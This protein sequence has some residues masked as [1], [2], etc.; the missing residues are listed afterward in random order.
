VSIPLLSSGCQA[1]KVAG[2]ACTVPLQCRDN[3][4]RLYILQSKLLDTF[5]DLRLD[6]HSL[7]D[8]T[9]AALEGRTP[10]D[11]RFCATLLLSRPC[12]ICSFLTWTSAQS[13]RRQGGTRPGG[14]EAGSASVEEGEQRLG[15]DACRLP[16]VM[17]VG[18]AQSALIATPQQEQSLHMACL[19]EG[20]ECAMACN[21]VKRVSES[22]LSK[23]R[24]VDGFTKSIMRRI[25]E[26]GLDI[27]T[28]DIS[29]LSKAVEDTIKGLVDDGVVSEA[30]FSHLQV[31]AALKGMSE[32]LAIDV[33]PCCF[34]EFLPFSFHRNRVL[35]STVAH[36]LV[37]FKVSVL[38]VL[39]VRRVEPKNTRMH[40]LQGT[41][42]T[43]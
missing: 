41:T 35:P 38:L 2:I 21:V 15:S 17:Y 28:G 19:H 8:D 25:Q 39:A 24:N 6:R 34:A 33:R 27:G 3:A 7:Q 36:L 9:W 5:E 1:A 10:F 22:N 14:A 43:S 40:F 32:D 13:L 16:V 12:T 11:T 20:M 37:L 18:A 29:Q 26:E 23:V 4:T 31:V 42:Y 30:D